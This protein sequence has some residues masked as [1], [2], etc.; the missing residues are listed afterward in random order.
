MRKSLP[1]PLP[2]LFPSRRLPSPFNPL[3]SARKRS[4]PSPTLFLANPIPRALPNRLAARPGFR[5]PLFPHFHTGCPGLHAISQPLQTPRRLFSASAHCHTD[6]HCVSNRPVGR[7][8]PPVLGARW[9]QGALTNSPFAHCAP[10]C[11]ALSAP[12]S[13]RAPPRH[14]STFPLPARQAPLAALCCPQRPCHALAAAL[15]PLP[16][17]TKPSPLLEVASH[18]HSL[19][20]LQGLA[21]PQQ[22][23]LQ[24]S[25]LYNPSCLFEVTPAEPPPHPFSLER[26]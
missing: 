1:R 19:P 26:T 16:E 3:S 5:S 15:V 22:A 13:H 4:A 10:Q 12:S 21:D 7:C 23:K 6:P 17:Q 11:P 14:Q 18:L 8:L 25:E 2:P 24:V 9:A 20:P